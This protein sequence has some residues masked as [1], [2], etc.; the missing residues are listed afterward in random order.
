MKNTAQLA[1]S[2]FIKCPSC[3]KLFDLVNYDDDNKISRAIFNNKWDEL[4][5]HEVSCPHCDHDFK[6]DEVEY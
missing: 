4:K 1:W 5:G 6:V 3:G 2:L